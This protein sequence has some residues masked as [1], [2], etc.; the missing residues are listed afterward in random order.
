MQSTYCM[1]PLCMTSVV[2]GQVPRE[3]TFCKYAAWFDCLSIQR[4][5][6]TCCQRLANKTCLI[7]EVHT[8]SIMR[9]IAPLWPCKHTTNCGYG[10][11]GVSRLFNFYP[12][13]FI[14]NQFHTKDSFGKNIHKFRFLTE[15]LN[16]SEPKSSTS[17]TPTLKKFRS[18][19]RCGIIGRVA[20]IGHVS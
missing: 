6:V 8:E 19:T 17:Q 2:H 1:F 14:W 15:I 16:I 3:R 4:T 5:A 20:V 18:K 7:R 13:P 10:D 9:M 12:P 11:V